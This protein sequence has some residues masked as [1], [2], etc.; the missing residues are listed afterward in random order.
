MFGV[1]GAETNVVGDVVGRDAGSE[2]RDV[3]TEGEARGL[4]GKER[5]RDCSPRAGLQSLLVQLQTDQS[6]RNRSVARHAMRAML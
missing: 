3:E 1:E 2:R 4:G 5:H 6:R